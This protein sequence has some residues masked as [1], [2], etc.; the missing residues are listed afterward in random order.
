[1]SALARNT[2]AGGAL[3]G[4]IF[5]SGPEPFIKQRRAIVLVNMSAGATE[6]Q[7]CETL[8]AALSAA[9]IRYDMA[10]ELAFLPPA[11]LRAGAE[12]AL[13]KVLEGECDLMVV[14]GGDGSVSTVANVLVGHRVRLGI[15]PLG[16]L[17]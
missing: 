11:E 4:V 13:Q 6:R 9:F 10:A 7:D 14:A 12:R 2:S 5:S 15:L 3:V 1:M 8:R 16:T 17:N